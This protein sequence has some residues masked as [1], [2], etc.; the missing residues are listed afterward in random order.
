LLARVRG[1]LAPHADV[2][3]AALAD[4][5]AQSFAGLEPRLRAADAFVFATGTHWDSWS[6]PLQRFLEDAT[7]AEASSLWLGKPVAGVVSE[8]STGGK[9]VLSRLQG[10]LVTLGCWVPP[11]SGL[12]LARS[13]QLAR[14][15]AADEA[16]DFWCMDDLPVVVENLL[17]AARLP[18]VAWQTWP[19]DRSDFARIWVE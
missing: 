5:G 1:F 4:P 10:V 8:H 16:E 9:G 17:L 15:H 19:V 18:R 11:L 2:E 14:R 6:S 7:Q 3:E 13:G 12:V